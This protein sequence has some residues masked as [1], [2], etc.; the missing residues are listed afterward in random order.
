MNTP[1]ASLKGAKAS[2][3]EFARERSLLLFY[4]STSKHWWPMLD[5][6]CNHL[7]LT[8]TFYKI[9]SHGNQIKTLLNL[10]QFNNK[11]TIS[12]SILNGKYFL[13]LLWYFHSFNLIASIHVLNQQWIEPSSFSAGIKMIISCNA[14][15]VHF[16][17]RT[18]DKSR[19]W[20]S[21]AE[22]VPI[23]HLSMMIM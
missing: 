20:M 5:S 9:I 15:S 13:Y 4:C 19:S 23:I 18:F 1:T 12:T 10:S 3:A 7:W 22:V 6:P 14:T 16:N 8:Y 17:P 2:L 11:L 21:H